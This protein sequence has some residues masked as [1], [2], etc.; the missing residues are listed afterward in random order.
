M[1]NPLLTNRSLSTTM[2]MRIDQL[3]RSVSMLFIIVMLT[4]MRAGP[5]RLIKRRTQREIKAGRT[6][7]LDD[8]E[9]AQSRPPEQQRATTEEDAGDM[10]PNQTKRPRHSRV[11]KIATYPEP[12]Y[13]FAYRNPPLSG[14]IINGLGETEPRP[15]RK[16]FHSNSYRI[17][18]AG[19]ERYYHANI[20]DISMQMIRIIRWLDR[21]RDGLPAPHS[22]PV[23]NSTQMAEYVKE[24]AKHFGAELVG[25]TKLTSDSTFEHFDASPYQS[26][27]CIAVSMDLHGLY[28]ATSNQASSAVMDGYKRV[29][30]AAIELAKR[31]RELGWNAIAASNVGA[32]TNEVLHLPLAVQAG[33]GQLG[34][35]GSLISKELGSNL[36]LATVLTN[37]PLRYDEPVDIGV[38][39]FCTRCQVCLTNCPPQAIFDTKQM[40]RGVE[41]WYVDFD[42]C[43]PYF[44]VN[45]SCGI[46][47]AVCPW[48]EPGRGETISL[49]MLAQ[50]DK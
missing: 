50:R 17:A 6:V 25:I 15:A 37:M 38:D 1:M 33:L 10:T 24:A 48:T 39:D 3:K 45:N 16:V 34:K 27:I 20:N 35:H 46:C 36:R 8:I 41:K 18:W 42:K 7:W 9:P 23:D 4:I 12:T 13:P 40:V 11:M 14:N 47:V 43:A 22:F 31:I 44:A 49:K 29:A 26:A 2:L 30:T 32:D 21:Q 28:Y 19:L 5:W